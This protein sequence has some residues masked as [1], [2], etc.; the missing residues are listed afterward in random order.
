MSGEITIPARSAGIVISPGAFLGWD[1]GKT[2]LERRSTPILMTMSINNVAI[3][4]ALAL[5]VFAI[6]YPEPIRGAGALTPRAFIPGVQASANCAMNAQESAILTA[7]R[8]DS[9]QKRSQ[10]VC[11]P[12]L[13]QAAYFHAQDMINRAYF[14]HI[15]PPPNSIG[16]NQMARNAGYILPTFYGTSVTANYIESIAAGYDTPA[17]VWSG[18]MAS[19]AHQAHLLGLDPF[20]GEQIDVGIAYIYGANSTYGRYWVVITARRGP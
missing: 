1:P 3:A 15:T 20:Y 17:A 9:R 7:M 6:P 5:L 16:P 19:T 12:A 13:R 2:G 11:S 4:A 10:L 8:S 18:W 14:G